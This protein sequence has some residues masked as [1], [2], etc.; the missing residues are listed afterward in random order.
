MTDEVVMKG[1]KFATPDATVAVGTFVVAGVVE[2]LSDGAPL[3]GKVI[4]VV[5]R[6]HLIDTP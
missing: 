5:E 2:A 4:V 6:R 1:G 3:H